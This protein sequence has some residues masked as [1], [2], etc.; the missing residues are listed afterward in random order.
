MERREKYTTCVGYRN[1]NPTNIRYVESNKWQGMRGSRGG[2]CVFDSM[3]SCYRATAIILFKYID[4]GDNTI[5]KMIRRWAPTTENPTESYIR[6]VC[7]KTG[8][9][10][11]YAIT[12]YS[13]RILPK[14]I[15]AMCGFECAGFTPPLADV[16]LGYDLAI[17]SV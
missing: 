8:V 9:A 4:R 6:Y 5:E 10:R 1:N 15:Q 2:F 11:D 3:S 12:K 16:E 14:V 7:H 13:R 17:T